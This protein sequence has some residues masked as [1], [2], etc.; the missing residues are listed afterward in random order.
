M[1]DITGRD[2]AIIAQALYY[3]IKYI[4]SLPE[5]LR[6]HSN[7]ADMAKLLNAMNPDFVNIQNLINDQIRECSDGPIDLAVA[8][9]RMIPQILIAE[10]PK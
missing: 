1:P 6:E 2:R 7:Q 3:A 5:W 4:D 9:H 10:T 8:K